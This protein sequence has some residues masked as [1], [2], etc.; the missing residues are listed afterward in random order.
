LLRAAEPGALSVDATL[1][2]ARGWEG[3]AVAA[4]SGIRLHLGLVP[5]DGSRTRAQDLADALVEPWH[6]VGMPL[7]AL[8]DVV[9]TPTCGLAGASPERA[10]SILR[11]AVETAAEINERAAG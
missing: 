11:A 3:L 5:T 7:S 4:E 2:G 1:L 10:R 8:A 6:R 9:V